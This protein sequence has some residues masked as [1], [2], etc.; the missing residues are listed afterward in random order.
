MFARLIA[1]AG[2]C[3]LFLLPAPGAEAQPK[4]PV[5]DQ[6]FSIRQDED[7]FQLEEIVTLISTSLN[8][9]ADRVKTLAI[10]SMHFGRQ[11][12]AD[13]RR[14]AEVII[15]EKLFEANPTVK[16]VQ[17]QEC[18][19]L[20]TKIVRGILKLRKGIP[21]NE[22]RIA[23]AQKLQVDGFI[24]IG[25]F[26]DNNQITVYLKV[27]EAQTGAIILVDELAGR[28]APKRDALTFSFGEMN[29]PIESSTGT[30][31]DHNALVLGVNET[32]QLTGRFSFG[33]DLNFYLDNNANNPDAII[34]L[35]VGI[36]LAPYLGF[37]VVQM[38]ASASRLLFYV[39]VGKLLSPQLEYANLF[40]AGLQFIVGDR[41][42]IIFGVNNFF[43]TDIENGNKVTGAGSELRFGYRF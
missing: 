30:S 43:E 26:K 12:D 7:L 9:V 35:D 18:Q 22:A 13:F 41:L 2:L 28:R 14:K 16:L 19:K 27:T 33:V 31:A 37:D 40:R 38:H 29:F 15:L 20:E 21:S 32:V 5:V 17:C 3:A 1:A 4:E 23:L 11:V 25:L 10:N 42:V 6:S 24:D 36:L 8:K 34:E 39:G